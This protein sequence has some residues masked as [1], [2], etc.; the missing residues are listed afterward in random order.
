MLLAEQVIGVQTVIK[1]NCWH[2]VIRKIKKV[3][4]KAHIVR[5]HGKNIKIHVCELRQL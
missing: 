4:D 1:G 3:R 5:F 2:Q